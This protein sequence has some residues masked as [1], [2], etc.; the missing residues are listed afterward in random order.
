MLKLRHLII[1]L[2]L[3]FSSSV[4]SAVQ[5]SI[6]IGLPNVNIGINLPAYPQLARVPGYP[7]YY[8]PQLEANFFFYDSMYWVYQDDNWYASSWYNGPWAL[9]NP[10]F[11]P[12]YVLRIPVRY[13]RQ[14]PA[15]FFGWR[16]DAPP[17]WGHHWG[18]D[19]EQHRRGWD[20]WDRRAVPAPAPLPA[21]QRQYSGDH[22]PRQM[23]QQRQL[24]QQN[25]RY[26]PRDP[27]VRQHYQERAGQRAPTQQE[28]RGTSEERGDR[29]RDMQR[30]APRQP[31]NSAT[32]RSQPL[33][34]GDRDIQRA[35]PTSPQQRHQEVQD[36]RQSPEQRERRDQPMPRYQDREER[37][38]GKDTT[39]E[40]RRKQEHEQ[41]RGRDR[42]R[43]E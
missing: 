14:P 2:G 10:G 27:V 41:E 38:Q 1:A 13:Y 12:V 5:V 21:Y 33:Q 17:R 36:R 4:Y 31:E 43:N 15:Y 9:V 26:Q 20:K 37:Q 28:R 23:E 7:V 35:T 22:Y 32:P 29:Q 24:Q 34:R 18:P 19:W 42:G 25:Y 30:S 8:A 3:L 16:P 11:V 40:P 39:R 6:G